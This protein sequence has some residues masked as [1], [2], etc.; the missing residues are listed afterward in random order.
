MRRR[1]GRGGSARDLDPFA[2]IGVGEEAVRGNDL[3]GGEA[4]DL[5]GKVGGRD[6]THLELAGRDVERGKCDGCFV[7]AVRALEH[8][9]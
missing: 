3:A 1:N 5:A 4:H 7:A 9:R 2:Q 6:F 8:A